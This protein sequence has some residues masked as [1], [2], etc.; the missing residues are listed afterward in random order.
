MFVRFCDL[1]FS[2]TALIILSPILFLVCAILRITGE[3]EVFY[4]QCRV[5]KGGN[6]FELLK[7]ATMLKDSPMLG[8]G[9]ITLKNDPRV[10][11][12]GKVLRKTKINELPQLINIFNG[13][14]SVVGPRPMVPNTYSKYPINTQLLLNEVRPGLT[15]V[16]SVFFRDEEA[17]LDGLDEP[18][19][20]YDRVILPYKCKL[21]EWYVDNATVSLYFRLIIITAIAV[22]IPQWRPSV[23]LFANLPSPPSE[24]AGFI[25][26]EL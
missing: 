12:F 5:G 20:F 3:R 11:P 7:F 4:R 24:L 6:N 19:D 23:R 25:N 26:S 22:V 17:I 9:D 13:D 8:A 15:G 18:R 14:M 1:I 10:L 2:L 21:E 16:G